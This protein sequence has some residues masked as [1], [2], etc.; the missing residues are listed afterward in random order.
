MAVAKKYVDLPANP[1]AFQFANDTS[2]ENIL[3][4]RAAGA[5]G[6]AV[7]QVLDS[8]GATDLHYNMN[9]LIKALDNPRT[10]AEEKKEALEEAM[11]VISVAYMKALDDMRKK[12]VSEQV[13]Q[14]HAEYTARTLA[15]AEF[16]KL[17]ILF[18]SSAVSLASNAHIGQEAVKSTAASLFDIGTSHIPGPRSGRG[19]G[20]KVSMGPD[21]PGHHPPIKEVRSQGV[22][23]TTKAKKPRKKSATKKN[24]K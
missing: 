3:T 21:E 6:G 17:D 22:L 16:A 15:T 5:G 9:Q 19:R 10:V 2:L 7:K 23:G 12:G 18:P 1:S 13:A 4:S 20:K 8:I 11:K 24:G 14:A